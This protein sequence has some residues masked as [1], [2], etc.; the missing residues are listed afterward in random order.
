MM[1]KKEHLTHT[2]L[3]EIINLRASLNWGLSDELKAAF[4]NTKPVTRPEVVLQK[5]KDPN[6]L[7]GFTSGE[8]CFN[9][10]SFNSSSNKSSVRLIFKITQHSRDA[11]LIE[12]LV[13]DLDCGAYYP[14]GDREASDFVVQK[15]SDI[16]EKIIPFFNKYPILGVKALDF[17]DFCK[18]AEIM[19]VKGHLTESGLDEIR[20]IKVGM[21]RGRES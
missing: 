7:A 5:I 12:N 20:K 17:A 2:G 8:G 11:Q 1:S 3:Q 15:F 14:Y 21:N 19:K 4:P 9:V 10:S 18:V 16:H 13:E 6:W